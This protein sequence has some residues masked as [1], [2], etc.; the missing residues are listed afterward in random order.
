MCITVI[1]I[2]NVSVCVHP[3]AFVW[4]WVCFSSEYQCQEALGKKELDIQI[5][6]WTTG[7]PEHCA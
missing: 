3:C 4:R 7:K 1:C 5:P 2:S 6:N